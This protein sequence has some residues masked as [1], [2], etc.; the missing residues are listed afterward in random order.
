MGIRLIKRR[1]NILRGTSQVPLF[2]ASTLFIEHTSFIKEQAGFFML[3]AFPFF[4]VQA[5][6]RHRLVKQFVLLLVGDKDI[7]GLQTFQ[8]KGLA[9][10]GTGHAVV[11]KFPA[12]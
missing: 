3:D 4:I 2:K 12:G 7:G 10:C 11:S 6:I 5:L 9:G 8:V 1:R